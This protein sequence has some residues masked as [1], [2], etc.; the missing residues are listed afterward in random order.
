MTTEI[1]WRCKD[2]HKGCEGRHWKFYKH[3][4]ETDAKAF[5][6]TMAP[7]SKHFKYRIKPNEQAPISDR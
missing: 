5:M 7:N 1:Q 3:L 6:E 4:S 2:F